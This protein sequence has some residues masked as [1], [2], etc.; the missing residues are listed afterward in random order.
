VNGIISVP[1]VTAEGNCHI[2]LLI[3]QRTLM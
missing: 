2:S 3:C 1:P